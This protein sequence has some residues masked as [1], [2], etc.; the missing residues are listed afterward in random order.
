[1]ITFIRNIDQ[2]SGLVLRANGGY[3]SAQRLSERAPRLSRNAISIDPRMLAEYVG[4]YSLDENILVRVSTT[5]DALA[6]QYSGSASIPMH[7]VAPDRF[8]DAD[9]ANGLNFTRDENNRIS[10]LTVELGGGERKAQPVHW[11]RP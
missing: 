6:V 7:A 5:A 4:D 10:G 2:I 9:G 3:V 11:R 1:V 8:V